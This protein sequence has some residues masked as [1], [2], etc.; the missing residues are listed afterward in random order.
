MQVILRKEAILGIG[1]A[2]VI[3]T[4]GASVV[5]STNDVLANDARAAQS[6][7]QDRTPALAEQDLNLQLAEG[8]LTY[9]RTAVKINDTST[10]IVTFP[11][12][13]KAEK[14][15]E[16]AAQGLDGEPE[17]AKEV[18]AITDTIPQSEEITLYQGKPVN[19]LT[20]QE[21]RDR[22]EQIRAKLKSLSDQDQAVIKSWEDKT[23][24]AMI[25]FLLSFS[26]TGLGFLY[27][28]VYLAGKSYDR[29]SRR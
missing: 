15:L 3:G 8:W 9:S 25:K 24:E 7:S 13:I 12:G 23:D 11:D 26:F 2:V 28:V 4:G 19:E 1:S 5:L 18:L 27:P 21:E 17:I 29:R 16:L 6:R 22:I 10:V 20:F 14:D